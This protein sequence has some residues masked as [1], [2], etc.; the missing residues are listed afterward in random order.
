MNFIKGKYPLKP[1]GPLKLFRKPLFAVI[2]TKYEDPTKSYNLTIVNKVLDFLS[3]KNFIEWNIIFRTVLR[4]L[5]LI[6]Y[7]N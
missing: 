4:L 1:L 7:I 2:I 5:R 3:E 6:K